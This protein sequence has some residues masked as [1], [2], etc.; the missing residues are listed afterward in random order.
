MTALNDTASSGILLSYIIALASIVGSLLYSLILILGMFSSV[1]RI[2]EYVVYNDHEKEWELPLKEIYSKDQNNVYDEKEWPSLGIITANNVRIRYRPELPLVLQGLTFQTKPGE[3]VGIVGRTGSGKST[4]L[5]SL[6]RILEIS[7]EDKK[8]H[9]SFIQIDGVKISSLGLHQ[10]RSK[11]TIIPQDPFLLEGTLKTNLDPF[12]KYKLTD[13]IEVLK[14]VSF[15]ES[16][17]E[18]LYTQKL[19]DIRSDDFE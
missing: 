6:M 16:I 12:T 7:E 8:E 3:K 2:H 19:G 1:E 10:L 11:V 5:L 13:I 18:E 14:Q 17:K 9:N 4:V 15:F